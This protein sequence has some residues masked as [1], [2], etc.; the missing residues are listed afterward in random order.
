MLVS[1][2]STRIS[3]P[4]NQTLINSGSVL[5]N[6][7]RVLRPVSSLWN[8]EFWAKLSITCTERS[9]FLRWTVMKLYTERFFT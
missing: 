3:V 9:L 6:T 2:L 1:L 4:L 7:L 5:N 8:M